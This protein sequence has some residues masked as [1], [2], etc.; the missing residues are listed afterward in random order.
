VSLRRETN[1]ST[2]ASASFQQDIDA[3]KCTHQSFRYQQPQLR[4]PVPVSIDFRISQL[5]ALRL[6]GE[7]KEGHADYTEFVGVKNRVHYT[8]VQNIS[9][10][11]RSKL[12]LFHAVYSSVI[13]SSSE[14]RAKLFLGRVV[15][16][17]NSNF[18]FSASW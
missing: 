14:Y 1:F 18:A 4:I 15:W 7:R 2:G 3:L 10:I 6:R 9:R 17:K 5:H 12:S 11:P 16:V 8:R 13:L